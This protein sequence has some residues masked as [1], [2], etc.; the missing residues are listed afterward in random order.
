MNCSTDDWRWRRLLNSRKQRR[1]KEKGNFFFTELLQIASFLRFSHH[2]WSWFDDHVNLWSWSPSVSVISLAGFPSMPKPMF[3]LRPKNIYRKRPHFSMWS[4]LIMGDI[5][6]PR[7]GCECASYFWTLTDT[8]LTSHFHHI[9]SAITKFLKEDMSILHTNSAKLHFLLSLNR[10][11]TQNWWHCSFTKLFLIPHLPLA[12]ITNSSSAIICRRLPDPLG[13]DLELSLT[14]D[15]SMMFTAINKLF[16]LTWL[17]WMLRRLRSG[18]LIGD[19]Q[20]LAHLNGPSSG[21]LSRP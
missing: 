3:F 4:P 8:L 7:W 20:F 10:S 6:D 17:L 16:P 2:P 19:G 14:L 12:C 21:A 13:L 15:L 1:R 5:Q 9:C 11:F 18:L